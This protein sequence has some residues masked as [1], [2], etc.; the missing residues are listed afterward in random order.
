MGVLFRV[1]C[2]WEVGVLCQSLAVVE[3]VVVV[4]VVV[5]MVRCCHVA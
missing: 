5:V 3:L 2:F 4:V 1:G